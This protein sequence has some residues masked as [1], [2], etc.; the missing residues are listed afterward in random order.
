MILTKKERAL[1]EIEAL[2][3]V[4]GHIRHLFPITHAMKQFLLV[5]ADYIYYH[6]NVELVIAS[7]GCTNK[8]SAPHLSEAEVIAD[9]LRK[10]EVKVP[11]LLEN[12]ACTTKENLLGVKRKLE[13]EQIKPKVILI[14]CEK[15]RQWKIRF[16]AKRILGNSFILLKQNLGTKPIVNFLQIAVVTPLEIIAHYFFPLWW[17]KNLIR[18]WQMR[19]Q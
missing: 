19:S 5:V 13:E 9:F 11:I 17:I 4:V 15:S 1:K 8:K 3:V 18:E 14:F 2:V 12:S 6:P 16:F 7:G 10:E